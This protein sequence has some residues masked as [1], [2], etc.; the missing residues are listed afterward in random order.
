M[1]DVK[2]ILLHV[3][4]T[5]GSAHRLEV[6]RRLASQYAARVT[7]LFGAAWDSERSSYAYS[8]G[9]ALQ[10]QANDWEKIARDEARTRLQRS[11]ADV[12]PKVTWCEVAGDSITHAFLGESVYADLLVVGQQP[13]ASTMGA[14]PGGFVET[15]ILKSGR[16]TLVLPRATGKE[17]VG[18]CVLVAWDGSAPAARAVAGSLPFLGRAEEVHVVSWAPHPL[19]ARF[20]RMDIGEFLLR[21]SVKAKLHHRDASAQVATELEAFAGTLNADLVVMGCYGHSRVS[22]RIFGGTSRSALARLPIPLLMVH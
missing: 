20:S 10:E 18:R 19:F 13:P 17:D 3:D 5:P 6:A 22:E 12:E 2:S 1:S 14:A 15:T 16:P 4:A 9:A 8:A 11:A 7:A 21:H